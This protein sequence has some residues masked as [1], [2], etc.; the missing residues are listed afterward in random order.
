MEVTFRSVIE[1]FYS[2][3]DSITAWM[4]GTSSIVAVSWR[5]IMRVFAVYRIGF[6]LRQHFGD[7]A[8]RKIKEVLTAIERSNDQSHLRQQ[9]IEAHLD[10]GVWFSNPE[11]SYTWVNDT[12]AEM[13]GI[14]AERMKG[15]GW[16]DGLES[17]RRVQIY[18]K[19]ETCVK[20]GIPYEECFTVV[21]RRTHE[22]IPIQTKAYV[23]RNKNGEA[24][25]FVGYVYR[26][27]AA[28]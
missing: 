1:W 5:R 8:G 27:E 2:H 4:V 13:F 11:G 6:E 15:N 3:W 25:C 18:D 12:L 23:V 16:V 19:W 10:I 7:D 26:L 17:D 14:D 21:N 22:R 9:L 28:D 20:K 24:E